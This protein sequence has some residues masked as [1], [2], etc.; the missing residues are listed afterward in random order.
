MLQLKRV[1]VKNLL[2]FEY[3]EFW[4]GIY[5]VIVG[6]NNSGKTNL[7]RILS[8][9]SESGNF[10]YQRISRT[11]KLNPNEPSEITITLNLDKAEAGMVFQ[12]IFG[13][14]DQIDK[15]AESVRTLDITIFWD[16]DQ[17]VTIS[18]K[19]TLYRFDSGFTISTSQHKPSIAFDIGRILCDPGMYEDAVEYWRKANLENLFT[20]R[21]NQWVTLQ[22]ANLSGKDQFMEDILE[23]RLFDTTEAHVIT[24]LPISARYDS[25]ADTPISRLVRHHKPSGSVDNVS[26]GFVLNMIFKDNITRIGEIRPSYENLSNSLA[27]LRN[28]EQDKYDYLRKTFEDISGGVEVRAEREQDGTEKIIFVEGSKKYD[29]SNSASGHHA[30]VGI[31]YK[32][33]G[34]TSGLIA[35]DEPEVHLHPT[36]CLR[37]HK[38]L[39]GRTMNKSRVQVIIVTHS[40]KFVTHEQIERPCEHGLIMVTRR[41]T[42]SQV[43]ADAKESTPEIRP[44]LF[45]PEIFFGRCTMMVEGSSDYFV[46]RAISDHRDGLLGRKDII[47]IHCD[48]KDNLPAFIDLHKRFNIPYQ[49][50][51]DGDY[52]GVQDSVIKLS[53]DLEAEL[54]TMGVRNVPEKADDY[55]YDQV[56]EFLEGT[57]SENLAKSKFWHVFEETIGKAGRGESA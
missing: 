8:V 4:L 9:M 26:L 22:Y 32:I 47:L 2:S 28:K 41:G 31:L 12:C 21:D 1:L 36:M 55:I 37:L 27:T 46:M 11:Q 42:A 51:A 3:V 15:M 6:P 38:M 35:I 48:G 24:G 43:H 54:G 17:S 52:D 16:K 13:K 49:A 50:M 34:K 19:F 23:G 56:M 39:A 14:N 57:E 18:P 40:T 20:Y 25:N 33:L 53:G 10:E 30:L 45:N 29:I 5:T 44:H 7:L